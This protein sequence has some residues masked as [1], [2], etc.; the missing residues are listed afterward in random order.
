MGSHS[1]HE[2]AFPIFFRI[3]SPSTAILHSRNN[4]HHDEIQSAL[5]GRQALCRAVDN[6]YQRLVTDADLLS[7]FVHANLTVL[8]WH[9]Y[10]MVAVAFQ[11][12]EEESTVDLHELVLHQHR[13]LFAMGLNERHFDK[14]MGSFS[15][16]DEGSRL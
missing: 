15:S 4:A 12:Q 11:E 13:N 1:I 16:H 6:F 7:F 5:G 2:F 14:V 3:M 8:K 10:N 9:Q